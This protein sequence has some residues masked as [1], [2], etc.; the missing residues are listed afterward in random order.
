MF[1]Q[2][3]NLIGLL[4]MIAVVGE[5][6]INFEAV[7]AAAADAGTQYLLVEQDD[8]HGEDP[9]DCMKR[10]YENLKALGLD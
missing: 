9:F 1:I 7:I 4:D 5:G 3:S 8:C 2:K 6:N 10:S